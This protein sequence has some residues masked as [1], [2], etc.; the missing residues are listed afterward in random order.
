MI[1][2]TSSVAPAQFSDEEEAKKAAMRRVATQ[3]NLGIV[4]MVGDD[5]RVKLLPEEVQSAGTTQENKRIAAAVG[6]NSRQRTVAAKKTAAAKTNA[7]LWIQTVQQV[8]KTSEKATDAEGSVVE[9][10]GVAGVF[11]GPLLKIIGIKPKRADV[12]R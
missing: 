2:V 12:T 8:N 4:D 10:E 11:S 9:K 5:W 6:K 3:F 1:N 7:A